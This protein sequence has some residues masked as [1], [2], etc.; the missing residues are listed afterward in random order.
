MTFTKH[1]PASTAATAAF[2][3]LAATAAAAEI[4]SVPSPMVQGGMIMPSIYITNADNL[5]N[6]TSGTLAVSFAP[7]N[8][9]LLASLQ[10][11]SPGSWFATNA[12]WRSDLG[13]PEGV[14]GT[15][16]ANAGN[17][18]LFSSR[19]GFNFTKVL[20][21][22]TNA[23]VPA[24]QSL[25]LRLTSFSPLLESYNYVNSGTNLVWD[26]IFPTTNSQVLW[27]GMMWHNF[28]T[29]PSNAPAGTYTAQ[30]E[31]FIAEQ[32]FDTN[33][34]TGRADYTLAAL[35]ALQDPDFTPATINYTWTVVPEPS[36]TALAALG[37]AAA[38]L[39]AWRR[40]R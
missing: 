35:S 34:G 20:F 5:D 23:S 29:V 9:P 36:T 24:G 39:F 40:R 8:V 22:V 32:A 21:G 7:T 16:A 37:L 38:A 17:G 18:D 11:Y 28:F 31:V 30:F 3:A 13:S 26:Q 19:Y 15:P 33:A 14:G 6:P 2:I 4:S 1:C 25:G 12:P 27:D 10:T